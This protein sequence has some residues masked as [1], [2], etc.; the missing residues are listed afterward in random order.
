MLF[1]LRYVNDNGDICDFVK[2][3]HCES[4]LT[5]K[6]YNE[7]TEGLHSFGLIYKFIV[8]MVMIM[9]VLFLAML[10]DFLNLIGTS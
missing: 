3:I 6:I 10:M 4:V 5:G 9:L 8:V 2:I 1:C 7:V